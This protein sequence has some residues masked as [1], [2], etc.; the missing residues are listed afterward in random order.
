M[1]GHSDLKANN[2]TYVLTSS[3]RKKRSKRLVDQP[4]YFRSAQ[5]TMVKNFASQ[6]IIT[7]QRTSHLF[8]HSEHAL[9][10]CTEIHKSI[11]N[12]MSR[13]EGEMGQINKRDVGK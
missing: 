9:I 13:E 6:K 2:Q 10:D 12:N 3:L 7:P 11:N 4:V 1:T 5:D 8:P